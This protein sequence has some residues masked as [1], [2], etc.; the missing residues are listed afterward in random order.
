MRVT[1][2]PPL[3]AAGTRAVSP[4]TGNAGGNGNDE[5]R[6]HQ[7]ADLDQSATARASS[8]CFIP[9]SS[10]GMTGEPSAG[11]A[12]LIGSHRIDGAALLVEGVAGYL[13]TSRLHGQP[14]G[15]TSPARLAGGAKCR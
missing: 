2:L 4:A 11:R 7:G 12:G 10:P 13:I 3:M 6:R 5:V 15:R 14:G 9:T 1:V 8:A